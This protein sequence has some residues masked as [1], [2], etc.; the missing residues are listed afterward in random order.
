MKIVLLNVENVNFPT[1]KFN[2]NTAY[3]IIKQLKAN[4]NVKLD[5]SKILNNNAKNVSLV[6]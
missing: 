5:T 1:K 2:A 3:K 6:V 4:V